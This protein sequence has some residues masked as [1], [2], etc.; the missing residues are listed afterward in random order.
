MT[1]YVDRRNE[2]AE[3]GQ[4]L[5][6]LGWKL[7]GWTADQS[8]SMTD[9]CSPE[10]WDGIATK[11]GAVCVVDL[12]AKHRSS[13]EKS[14]KSSEHATKLEHGPCSICNGTGKLVRDTL[15]STVHRIDFGTGKL[16]PV[17][18]TPAEKA[19]DTCRHCEGT[20]QRE[21]SRHYEKPLDDPWPTFQANPGASNW[22]VE[23]D[24][25]ILAKGTGLNACRRWNY[26]DVPLDPGDPDSSTTRVRVNPGA[27]ALAARIDAA[28]GQQSTQSSAPAGPVS[29]T[30]NE[31]RDGLEIRFTDKPDETI[32]QAL[33]GAGFRWHF[34]GHFWYAKHT[35]GREA[36]ARSLAET[37]AA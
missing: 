13:T 17:S 31:E 9:Y 35:E 12:S 34:T 2:V 22:H 33:K 8:D 26:A 18:Q 16:V 28:A 15:A 27:D 24:G 21:E 23:R 25:K 5:A 20:G 4:A 1:H 6:R 11:Q 7:Y 32:R 37:A 14:G 10:H 30:R 36:F 29:V 19:G 3:L